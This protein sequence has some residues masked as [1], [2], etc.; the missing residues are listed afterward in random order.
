MS[1]EGPMFILA[2][3]GPY[4][5]RGCEAIIRG[6]AKILRECFRDPCIV[7][8][9]HFHSEEQFFTQGQQET[10][11]TIIH[12]TSKK[13][14]KK[15]MIKS[16]WKFDSWDTGYQYLFNQKKF[17]LWVYQDM[18]PYLNDASAVLS[19]GGDNYSLDYGIP[20][21]F[22][23]LDNIV[24]KNGRPQI[25]WGASIGPFTRMPSYEQYMSC[26]LKKVTGIFARETNTVEYL[27]SIGL[28]ENVYT[29]ADP[30][31]L[32]DSVQPKEKIC[33]EEDS[34]GLNL[35]PLMASYVT[36]GDLEQWTVMAAAIIAE[37]T[38]ATKRH[39]Y[40]IPHVT[41]PNSNDYT[42]MRRA[43]SLI[44]GKKENITL[45]SAQYTAAELKWIISQMAFFA[46]ART[47]ATIAALSSGVPTLSFAYSIKARGIN[48]DIFGH[49]KFCLEP[50]VLDTEFVAGRIIS[51]L[52]E[53]AAIR[54]YLIE[55]IPRI[56]Q[57][58]MNAGIILKQL[59]REN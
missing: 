33:I 58:A 44:S 54:K 51:M 32:M 3:N 45:V 8:L 37:V 59:I 56:Q 23:A 11:P 29:V 43:L 36:K 4:E 27:K 57:A 7:C 47:H 13:F 15:R 20:T 22:T 6:T 41:N 28:R 34:I 21:R 40:L 31:F 2:G 38:R 24:L 10:D 1:E 39:I 26:H 50:T 16:F 25:I 52:D 18:I 12:L 19:I 46:G 35:S 48:R 9:S 49:N 14:S 55:R 5:N 30:A 42:F 53:D 17:F